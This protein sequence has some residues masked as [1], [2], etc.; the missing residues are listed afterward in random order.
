MEYILKESGQVCLYNTT[1][2]LMYN[3]EYNIFLNQKLYQ[4]VLQG[5][6]RDFGFMMKSVMHEEGYS[7]VK[8]WIQ[9]FLWPQVQQSCLC[10]R[11]KRVLLGY[12]SIDEKSN[13]F[14]LS[15]WSNRSFLP[16]S[17]VCLYNQQSAA[18]VDQ[19]SIVSLYS[20]GGASR[21]CICLWIGG[22]MGGL[23]VAY[24]VL[25][26]YV[27]NYATGRSSQK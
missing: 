13:I 15:V 21:V 10:V 26:K 11:D 27:N 18:Y 16:I 14:F 25:I 2:E 1:I 22:G 5:F 8:R 17:C 9:T 12:R 23:G 19:T 7:P 6:K 24:N 3:R 20:A 4:S